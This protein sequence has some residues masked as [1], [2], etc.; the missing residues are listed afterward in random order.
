MT[1]YRTAYLA[2]HPEHIEACAAYDFAHW[3]VQ[4]K[5]RSFQKMVDKYKKGAQKGAMPLTVI[6]L[7]EDNRPVGMGSLWEEDGNKWTNLTPWIASVFV[8]YRHRGHGI[9]TMIVKQLEKEAKNL[10]F[11]T[12]FLTSGSAGPVYEKI[13]Y[14]KVET[15]PHEYTDIGKQTLYRKPLT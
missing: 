14:Q 13:G 11:E 10:G 15:V 9:A 12:I 3:S 2:D 8:H 1:N 4:H 6:V 5:D 7:N